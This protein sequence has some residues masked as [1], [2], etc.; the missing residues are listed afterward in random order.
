MSHELIATLGHTKALEVIATNP[1]Y[2]GKCE[3][4]ERQTEVFDCESGSVT[5]PLCFIAI[6][7]EWEWRIG[8]VSGFVFS[9]RFGRTPDE[10]SHAYM[11]GMGIYWDT[12]SM[13]FEQ[14][15]WNGHTR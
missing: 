11:V 15:T 2:R 4:C 8:S 3:N 9:D 14:P 7:N 5:C 10:E 13:W 6:T 1:T 12:L